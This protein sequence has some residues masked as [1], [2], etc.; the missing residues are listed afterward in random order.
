LKLD[1]I[2]FAAHPDD[3]E[4]C[5]GG[6]IIKLVKSG[7]KTGIVDLTRGELSTRGA[8]RTRK[9]ELEESNKVLGIALREN[10]KIP[11]GNIEN[12]EK[13]RLRVIAVIRKYR[14]EII[15]FPHH[16]DRHPDHYH[17]HM[18]VKSAAFYSGLAKIKTA[19]PP[20]MARR[21]F[22]YMQSYVFE[23]NLITDISETFDDKMK[24]IEC[25]KSQFYNPNSREPETYISSKKFMEFIKARAKFYG[26][27]IGAEYGEP[28][29]TEEKIKISAEGLF[30]I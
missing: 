15:F 29:F 8:S 28:F 23:P 4:L 21:N 6:T 22:C 26:F 27:Q 19:N 18:L 25:Y 12:N 17:T 20:H 7:K 5:C 11:D 14:P 30:A 2:F 24:S 16:F 9:R 3:A 10:L 13:N 1:A